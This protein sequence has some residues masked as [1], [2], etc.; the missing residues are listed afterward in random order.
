MLVLDVSERPASRP[1]TQL[2]K[3][4][5]PIPMAL[6][7]AFSF[8]LCPGCFFWYMP[9]REATFEVLLSVFV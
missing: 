8:L 4:V 6:M 7:A 5:A 3:R 9:E 2:I 1:A